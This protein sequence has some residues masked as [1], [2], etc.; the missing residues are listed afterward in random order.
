MSE[1]KYINDRQ[2]AAILAGL[3]LLQINM[4]SLTSGIENILTSDGLVTPLT[5]EEI[6]ELCETINCSFV[7]VGEP[8]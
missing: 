5:A 6:D 4:P 7:K 3:R 2:T 1:Q 8:A